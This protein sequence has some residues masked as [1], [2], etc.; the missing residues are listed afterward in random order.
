VVSIHLSNLKFYA[1]HGLFAEEKVLGGEYEVNAEVLVQSDDKVITIQQTVD[2]TAIYSLI[3]QQMSVP[4]ELL[5][6]LSQNMVNAIGLLDKR[7]K[8]VSIH[9]KKLHPPIEQFTGS[10]GVTYS[11]EF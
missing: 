10:I 6:T 8:R 9:I 5:E 3:N 1:Y 2:Y 4:T 11:K 7:I